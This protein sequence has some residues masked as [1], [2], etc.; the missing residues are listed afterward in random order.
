MNAAKIERSKPGDFA[1]DDLIP[2]SELAEKLGLSVSAVRSMRDRG[3]PFL[4]LG[5]G[6]PGSRVFFDIPTAVSWIVGHCKQ[7]NTTE[8]V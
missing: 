1:L 6:G 8:K 3:L 5:A 2:E 4:R 7:Q